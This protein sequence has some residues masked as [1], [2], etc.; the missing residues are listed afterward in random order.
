[1]FDIDKTENVPTKYK[2]VVVHHS[3]SESKSS[4]G[5]WCCKFPGP[6]GHHGHHFRAGQQVGVIA[7]STSSHEKDLHDNDPV[8]IY[9]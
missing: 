1:M 5:Q 8:F 6:P 3:S 9:I 4:M 2:D 7:I